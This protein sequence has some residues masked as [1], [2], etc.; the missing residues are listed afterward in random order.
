MAEER[1]DSSELSFRQFMPWTQI[2]RGFRIA[3]N[4]K[5]LLLA[6]AGILVMAFGW[7]L[8]ALIFSGVRS[9]PIWPTDY[10]TADYQP[11]VGENISAEDKAWEAF[12]VDRSRWDLLYE[13]AGVLPTSWTSVTLPRHALSTRSWKS[14]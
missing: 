11:A 10:Q 6:A 8:L 1:P 13:A 12:K 5:S 3:L 2:F 14:R 4:P 7:W 9:K